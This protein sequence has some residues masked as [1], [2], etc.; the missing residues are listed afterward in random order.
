MAELIFSPHAFFPQCH[1]NCLL[2]LADGRMLCAYFAGSYE[3]ADD[4]GIWLSEFDGKVWLSPRQ[5]VKLD[6][7]PHWNPVLFS[8]KNGVRMV[9]KVG[10]TIPQWRSYTMISTDG[11]HSWSA[12][13]PYTDNPAGGPVR[14]KPI[15]LSNGWLLAPNSDEEGA[16]LPR[17]D[18]SKNEGE[19]FE[20]WGQIPVNLVYPNE[21]DFITGRG[22]IQP[23][24]WESKPGTVHALLRTSAG[25]IFR[26]DSVDEGR[27]WTRAR[28]L[29]VPNNNS[30]FDVVRAQDGRLFLALNPTSGDFVQRTPLSIYE[31]TDNGETFHPFAV[32]NDTK[33]NEFT[34]ESAEFSY[35]SLVADGKLLHLTYTYNRRSIAYWRGEILS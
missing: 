8:V 13:H 24:L 6:E 15:R 28:P 14:S 2:P 35:P 30:G 34:G 26:S 23:T 21:P 27:T 16:W 29:N 19:T 25:R 10:K 12:P 4:V 9:F 31:S 17:V 22:A 18:I 7:V 3:M 33:V 11:G 1:A 32:V 5:I 20:R